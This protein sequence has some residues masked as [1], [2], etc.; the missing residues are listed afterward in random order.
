M[1]IYILTD[2]ILSYEAFG[3]TSRASGG[4]VEGTEAA[5]TIAFGVLAALVAIALLALWLLKEDLAEKADLIGAHAALAT[6]A[7]ALGSSAGLQLFLPVIALFTALIVALLLCVAHWNK[8]KLPTRSGN[9]SSGND[10]N[11]QVSTT[12]VAP[13]V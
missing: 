3:H 6:V 1:Y 9:N 2:N 12:V 5:L 11:T 13:P 7:I 4:F 8:L 10:L